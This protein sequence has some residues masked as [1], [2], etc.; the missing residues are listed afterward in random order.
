MLYAKDPLKTVIRF[1]VVFFVVSWN[2][3]LWFSF[4]VAKSAKLDVCHDFYI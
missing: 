2:A 4:S 3:V 1:V